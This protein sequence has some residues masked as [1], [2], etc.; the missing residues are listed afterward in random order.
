MPQSRF[1]VRTLAALATV[2]SAACVAP[3]LELPTRDDL[4]QSYERFDALYAARAATVDVA[5]VNR[6]FDAATLDFFRGQFGAAIEKIDRLNDI[7]EPDGAKADSLRR[8]RALKTRIRPAVGVL[9]ATESIAVD[10]SLLYAWPTEGTAPLDLRVEIRDTAGAILATGRKSI[11]PADFDRGPVRVELSGAPTATGN[12]EVW[13]IDGASGASL[14]GPRWNVVAKAPA[15]ARAAW[16]ERLKSCGDNAAPTTARFVCDA[17]IDLFQEQPDPNR[18]AESRADLALLERELE[19]E[20]T[21]IC[22]GENPYRR[23]VGDYWRPLGISENRAPIRIAAPPSAAGDTPHPLIVAF[24]GAGGDEQMFFE[25][26]GDG[27]LLRAAMAGGAIVVTPESTGFLLNIT[28]FDL[29]LE[30]MATDYAIDPARIYVLGHSLGGGVALQVRR[31]YADRIAA[32]CVVAGGRDWA[33]LTGNTPTRL[34]V[35]MLD[36]IVPPQSLL[37][38]AR[39]AVD[40]GLALTIIELPDR[41]HTLSIGDVTPEIVEWLLSQRRK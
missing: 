28:N 4:A 18:T 7:F 2:V 26:Y 1:A 30:L 16:R 13:F 20:V 39:T 14:R 38:D 37:R 34:Y 5:D 3:P 40:A 33:S 35:P 9:S 6:R 24:H 11:G 31:L 15:Q 21:Q 29:L 32:A 41:G 12:F 27:A 23:R 10:L 8:L 25:A 19:S 22:A 36:A 17:R